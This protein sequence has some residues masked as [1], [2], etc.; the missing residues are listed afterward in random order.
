MRLIDTSSLTLHDFFGTDIPEYCILSHRWETEEV[1]FRDLQAKKGD[2]M[3][4]YSKILGCCKQAVLD[5]WQYAWIDSCCIDKASSAELSEAINSMFLWYREAQVCYAYLS[6]VPSGNEVDNLDTHLRKS[7]W[8]TRGWTRQELLAPEF[9]VF[10]DEGWEEMGT[11]STLSHIIQHITGIKDIIHWEEACIAQKMSWAS[12]RKTTR[13]EDMAYSPLGIFGVYLPPLYGEGENAFQRLQLEIISKFDDESIFAWTK[14]YFS[15]GL[16]ATS[17]MLAT[18]PRGFMFSSDVEVNKT[19]SVTTYREKPYTM[20][21]LGLRLEDALIQAALSLEKN[22]GASET[23]LWCI[24]KA[25]TSL[26]RVQTPIKGKVQNLAYI[27]QMISSK[28]LKGEALS[29]IFLAEAPSAFK[30]GFHYMGSGEFGVA[31]D[32]WILPDGNW[33]STTILTTSRYYAIRYEKEDETS[34]CCFVGVIENHKGRP[35]VHVL[36]LQPD[37]ALEDAWKLYIN[38][39]IYLPAV[40]RSSV[41]LPGRE[42][43]FVSVKRMRGMA[44]FKVEIGVQNTL[45]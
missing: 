29:V 16:G 31:S 23:N 33:G 18:S 28:P 21:N 39:S 13:I 10:F 41:A 3:K 42:S 27:K 17:G 5:G 34:R 14:K 44:D 24:V 15:V 36:P 4:G 20:T 2:E 25:S 38:A 43:V 40:D 8:F 7:K 32:A 11:K 30:F 26:S 35:C 22:K 9:V 37:E 6:D 45:L 12:K 1:T 19:S